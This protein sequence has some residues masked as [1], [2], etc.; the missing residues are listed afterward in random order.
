M[1][2]ESNCDLDNVRFYD[3]VVD[4]Q[5]LV[6]AICGSRIPDM[7]T[8]AKNNVIIVAK[9]SQNFDGLGFRMDII[10]IG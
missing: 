8:I 1:G 5:R 2:S 4:D 7:F 9:K 10:E 3:S 6:K